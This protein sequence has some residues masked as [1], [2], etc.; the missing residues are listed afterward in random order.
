MN[1]SAP[2]NLMITVY[3]QAQ[4]PSGQGEGLPIDF[5]DMAYNLESLT[6]NRT[7]VEGEQLY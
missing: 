7:L 2:A 4:C 1:V 3:S 5:P 6:L